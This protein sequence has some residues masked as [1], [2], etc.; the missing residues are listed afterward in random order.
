MSEHSLSHTPP[1]PSRIGVGTHGESNAD[2]GA[3][4][5]LRSRAA[6]DLLYAWLT[7]RSP[8]E[9]PRPF[10]IAAALPGIGGWRAV[11]LAFRSLER[12]GLIEERHGTR[13]TPPFHRLVRIVATGKE[14]RT[15][16]CPLTFDSTPKPRRCRVG[17]ET[18]TA[19][20]QFVERCAERGGRL[21][22]PERLGERIGRNA[23]TAGRALAALRD[24]GELT[25]LR[26][27]QRRVAVLPDG[28]STL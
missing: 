3:A 16:G 19:V 12:R 1:A 8:A 10:E 26:H 21:P 20:L 13:G 6:D 24:R 28:R 4:G 25:L 22:H 14:M 7:A 2:P 15:A 17:A 11:A 27:G 5:A 23:D 9:L 18:L